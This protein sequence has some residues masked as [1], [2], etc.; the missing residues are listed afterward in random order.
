M[1]L[2]ADIITRSNDPVRAYGHR[3]DRLT[4]SDM[5]WVGTFLRICVR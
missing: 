1:I 2:L 4:D 5:I 3:R